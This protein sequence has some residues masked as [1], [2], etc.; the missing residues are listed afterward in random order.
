M[1]M[2]LLVLLVGCGISKGDMYVLTD[3]MIGA[4]TPEDFIAA[5]EDAQQ[6]G[7][8]ETGGP[9]H[10]IFDED[11][12]KII[13]TK[14]EWVLIE[15]IEGYDEGEQWWVSKGDLEQYAEKQ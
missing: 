10:T 11:I 7:T 6:D 12:V 5:L 15:I 3:M 4:D 2:V 8:L 1:L 9:I 13:D 14:D